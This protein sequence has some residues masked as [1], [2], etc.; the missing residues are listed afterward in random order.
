MAQENV[1]ARLKELRK[2]LNSGEID[3]ETFEREKDLLLAGPEPKASVPDA[4]I[5]PKGEAA[6]EKAPLPSQPGADAGGDTATRGCKSFTSHHVDE[7]SAPV[8]AADSKQP[9][10]AAVAKTEATPSVDRQRPQIVL[11]PVREFVGV[12]DS[13]EGETEEDLPATLSQSGG[14]STHPPWLLPALAV[15]AAVVVVVLAW[16][17]IG[18]SRASESARGVEPPR[19]T[20]APG[21]LRVEIDP[22]GKAQLDAFLVPDGGQRVSGSHFFSG[23]EPRG[24]TLKVWTDGYPPVTRQVAITSG[25]TRTE[26]VRLGR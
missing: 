15:G 2:R 1:V 24:Y 19:R 8:F 3:Q 14:G 20:E 17:L 12:F 13:G 6:P 16:L 9:S 4:K 18:S 26:T 23:L 10:R 25:D 11:P 22:P 7:V 5:P 21:A